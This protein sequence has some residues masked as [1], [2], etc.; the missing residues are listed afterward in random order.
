MVKLRHMT[1]QKLRDCYASISVWVTNTFFTFL[2]VNIVLGLVFGVR[3][4]QY[5][6][7]ERAERSEILKA[8][9]GQPDF[10][11][12]RTDYQLKWVDL[13]AYVGV[14]SVRVQKVLDD[15]FDLERL[16]YRFSPYVQY[17]NVPFTS[18]TVNIAVD[19]N[20]FDH[21]V[22]PGPKKPDKK[23]L[24]LGGST[25]FGTHV[26]DEWTYGAYLSGLIDAEILNFGRANYSW[27]QEMVLFQR[28][29]HAG[30]RPR[31][32]VFMDGVNVFSYDGVPMWSDKMQT[33][34]EEA[35]ILPQKHTLP[36][37][38]PVFRL[39]N[40]ITLK[41]RQALFASKMERRLPAEHTSLS[42]ADSY[43]NTLQQIRAIGKQFGIKPIFVLQPNRVIGCDHGQY[44]RE[45]P[46]SYTKTVTKFY[47]DMKHY[48]ASDYIDL[49]GLCNE[50]GKMKH[51]FI[52]DV[53]YSP[54]FNQLVAS[55]LAPLLRPLIN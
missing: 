12:R 39:V 4:V 43:Q 45:V 21:R 18:G 2:A 50:Y 6:A 20:G 25:T 24:L 33:L 14:D 28:L 38:I 26:A 22:V 10:T 55:K 52:D 16:G 40:F 47:S 8:R 32:V 9:P 15:F 42:F 41:K 53:H 13:R 54:E 34:W 31:A 7:K 49:S 51:A 27:F 37:F 11:D 30:H 48:Q 35:Q 17:S 23:I 1:L 5:W 3:E 19:K 46:T 36:D 44:T 29:V